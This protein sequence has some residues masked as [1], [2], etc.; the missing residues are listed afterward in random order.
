M[1]SPGGIGR[2]CTSSICSVRVQRS[3]RNRCG[4]AEPDP[5]WD[6][7]AAV[8]PIRTTKLSSLKLGQQFLYVFD[9][10]DDWTHLCTVADKLIDPAEAVGLDAGRHAWSVAVLGLGVDSGPVRTPLE[11]RHRRRRTCASRSEAC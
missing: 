10:G 1:R 3:R 2:I 8:L 11:R 6:F 7:G 4:W 5:D 9:L